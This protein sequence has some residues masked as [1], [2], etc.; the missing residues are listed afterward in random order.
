MFLEIII[1]FYIFGPLHFGECRAR[2]S[3]N[4]VIIKII[5]VG[6]RI[7]LKLIENAALGGGGGVARDFLSRAETN[8]TKGKCSGCC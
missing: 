7:K 2:I 1:D 6:P 8:P 3:F 4:F 5:A